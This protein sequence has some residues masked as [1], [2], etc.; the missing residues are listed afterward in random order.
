RLA[1]GQ[2]EEAGLQTLRQDF[3]ALMVALTKEQKER[4]ESLKR[5]SLKAAAQALPAVAGLEVHHAQLLQQIETPGN[6]LV[7]LE[8]Y[9]HQLT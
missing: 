3:S 2:P 1:E 8:N 7:A 4:D 6:D 5:S 9:L